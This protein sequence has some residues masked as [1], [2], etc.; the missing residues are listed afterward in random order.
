MTELENEQEE[1]LSQLRQEIKLTSSKL[2]DLTYNEST[3]RT[4][5]TS[6]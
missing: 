1:E 6:T 2:L 5:Q 3:A 4:M